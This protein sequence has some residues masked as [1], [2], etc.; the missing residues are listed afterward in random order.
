MATFLKQIERSKNL[1]PSVIEDAL[2]LEI[3]KH[4]AT[5]IR[6]NKNRISLDS[7]DVFGKALGFYT[8]AT[9]ILSGGVKKQGDPF[10]GIDTGDWFEGFRMNVENNVVSFTSIDQKNN[11]ILKSDNWL[12]NDV[13]GLND[14]DLK[15]FIKVVLKPFILSYYKK[16]LGL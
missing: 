13:F 7:E 3:R 5:L 9:E 12:S 16:E 15:S 10:T 4:E 14:G 8:Q 11:I 1:T 6:L 2:F